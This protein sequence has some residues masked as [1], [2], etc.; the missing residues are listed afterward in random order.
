M[1]ELKIIEFEIEKVKAR[2]MQFERVSKVLLLSNEVI[3]LEMNKMLGIL[4]EL[5]KKRSNLKK[6]PNK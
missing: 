2:M 1:E 6:T 5:I 3:E 4:S